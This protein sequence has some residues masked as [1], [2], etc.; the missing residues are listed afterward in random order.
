MGVGVWRKD[1]ERLRYLFT[2]LAVVLD[3]FGVS[4]EITYYFQ[5]FC[6]TGSGSLRGH[7]SMPQCLLP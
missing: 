7:M 1:Q 2:Y 3:P 4:L 5:S 6:V